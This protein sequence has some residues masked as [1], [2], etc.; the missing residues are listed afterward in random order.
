LLGSSLPLRISETQVRPGADNVTSLGAAGY[1]WDE[2]YA[3]LPVDTS[4]PESKTSALVAGASG[5]LYYTS[6][7]ARYKTNIADL[8]TVFRPEEWLKVVPRVY[9]IKVDPTG[10][11]QIGFIAE[12]LH[13]L[14]LTPVVCYKDGQPDSIRYD[15][16][17]VY[18]TALVKQQHDTLTTQQ[19][20]IDALTARLD[21]LESR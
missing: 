7:S 6:S 18:L 13:D 2:I 11:K 17:V 15:L 9:N 10:T 14:G 21:A 19:A 5:R 12:E 8:D 1:R 3:A 4:D 16:A 20:Q